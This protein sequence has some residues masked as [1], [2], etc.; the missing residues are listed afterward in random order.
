[1][2]VP[3]PGS[4]VWCLPLVGEVVG[5]M[6]RVAAGNDFPDRAKM[7]ARRR[8]L[9]RF[10]A[11]LR[12]TSGAGPWPSFGRPQFVGARVERAAALGVIK[13]VAMRTGSRFGTP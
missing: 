1:M 3:I 8:G 13:A 10:L 7:F 6:S 2:I 12:P 11:R 9:R 4:C 5:V